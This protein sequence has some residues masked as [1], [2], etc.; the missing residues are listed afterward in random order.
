VVLEDGWI[1]ADHGVCTWA[2]TAAKSA[3]GLQGTHW[4]MGARVTAGM[5]HQSGGVSVPDSVWV[6]LSLR[7]EQ[8]VADQISLSL[9]RLRES[10]QPVRDAAAQSWHGSETSVEPAHLVSCRIKAS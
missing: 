10:K 2:V 6:T 9:A 8:D 5:N 3:V 7:A 4:H 1:V